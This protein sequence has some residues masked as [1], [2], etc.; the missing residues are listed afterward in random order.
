VLPIWIVPPL[1]CCVCD[2]AACEMCRLCLV[3]FYVWRVVT[4]WYSC[5]MFLLLCFAW[6]V[7]I[8]IIFVWLVLP[9]WIVPPLVCCVCDM[10]ACEMCRLW[11][12]PASF[13]HSRCLIST[14][15]MYSRSL[16]WR[17]LN[18]WH[19]I[20]VLTQEGRRNGEKS[21]KMLGFS[22]FSVCC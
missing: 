4:L 21:M 1:V 13:M 9:I 12:R 18:R 6:L 10:A 2:M 3:F 17:P 20:C 8:K 22:F 19:I 15:S 14:L 5:I 16:L 11:C 7:T